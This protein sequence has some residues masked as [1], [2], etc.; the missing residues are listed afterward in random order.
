MS[1]KLVKVMRKV[2][3]TTIEIA[4]KVENKKDRLAIKRYHAEIKLIDSLQARAEKILASVQQREDE[5]NRKVGEL[6]AEII[7]QTNEL[8]NMRDGV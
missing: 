3:L 6:Q 7:A 4:L 8:Q 2:Y 5:A 1:I